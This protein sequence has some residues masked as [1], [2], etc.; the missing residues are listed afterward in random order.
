MFQPDAGYV[1]IANDGVRMDMQRFGCL[2]L[3]AGAD[4]S[5]TNKSGRKPGDYVTDDAIKALLNTPS[6]RRG[7]RS[8]VS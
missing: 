2:L 5:L 6:P 7:R 8:E 3:A 4:P 1:P